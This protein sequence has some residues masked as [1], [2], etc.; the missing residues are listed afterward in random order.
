VIGAGINSWQDHDFGAPRLEVHPDGVVAD[1]AFRDR[2]GREVE[3]RVDDRDGR[4]R[5]RS[6]LLAPIGA[7]ID[8]PA[9]LL[10][11]YLT[12]FDLVRVG[13]TPPSIRI[14]GEEVSTGRL[15]GQRLH[16]RALIKYA[17]NLVVARV[18][19]D[20]DSDAAPGAPLVEIEDPRR[21]DADGARLQFA[22][23]LPDLRALAPGE[24]AAGRWRLQVAGDAVTGGA[25]TLRRGTGQRSDEVD[26]VFDDLDRWRPRG[27]MPLLMRLV[28]T[29]VPTFRRWPTTYRWQGTVTLGAPPTLR[30]AWERVGGDGGDAY[31]RATQRQPLRPDRG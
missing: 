15:P 18:N 22:P 8:H 12:E 5:Q 30:G 10:I 4:P 14:D 23:P 6:R 28:T 7:G 19:P 11:V 31:R 24:E 20:A 13:A 1:V 16:R 3:V 26:V 29:V 25:W 17:A 21:Y 2:D 9:S 27:R